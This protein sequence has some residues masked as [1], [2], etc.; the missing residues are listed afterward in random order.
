MSGRNRLL[1]FY[2][3]VRFGIKNDIDEKGADC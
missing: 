1:I 3:G 2:R